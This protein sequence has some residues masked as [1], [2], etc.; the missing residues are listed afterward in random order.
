MSDLTSRIREKLAA[1]QMINLATVTEVGTP[2]VRYVMAV[3][4]DDLTMRVATFLGSRKV[5][6]INQNPEVHASCGVTSL[7]EASDYLQIQA[8]AT[9]STDEAERCH[10]WNDGLKAYFR[11]PDD[12]NLAVLVLKPY[13]IELQTM[14]SMTPEVW[15][16][17]Y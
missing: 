13:R 14:A 9:V 11:G 12:P 6:Q 3:T 4:D 5:A 15:E 10:V 7:S 2:W 16:S 8:R 17:E 1:P